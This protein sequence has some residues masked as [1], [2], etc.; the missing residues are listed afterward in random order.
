MN[1]KEWLLKAGVMLGSSKTL[2]GETL[3]ENDI[4]VFG[5]LGND[6]YFGVAN[7]AFQVEGACNVDGK[8][9]SIWDEFSV[10]K[11][12]I[13]NGHNALE[14]CDFY[15]RFSED[16][17]LAKSLGFKHFRFSISWTRV[18][19]TD[20]V[21]KNQSGINFYKNVLYAILK[22]GLQPW[23][24]LY[25]WD[26]PK[27][28]EDEGGWASRRV[29]Q[30]FDSYVKLCANE[31]GGLVERWILV[32]EPAAFVSL[33][34]LNGYHAPGRKS[35]FAFL[36]AVHYVCLAVAQAGRSLREICPNS[37]VGI[38]YNYSPVHGNSTKDHL[39]VKR[40]DAFINRLFVEPFLG[41][42]YPSGDLPVLKRL[43]RYIDSGDMDKIKFSF[44]FVG[45]QYY[46][47]VVV[48]SSPWIPFFGGREIPAAKRG[49]TMNSMKRE[50]YPEGMLESIERFHAYGFKEIVVT[51]NGVCYN[52]VLK[53]INDVEVIEDQKRI[54][55]YRDHLEQ[56]MIAK[57]NGAPVTG[58]FAWS[59]TD[60]FEW[61]E[62]YVDR[63]GL[64]YLDFTTQ[65]RI[66]K[67]SGRWWK[68]HLCS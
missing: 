15:H 23:V 19:Q 32:N 67:D 7:A 24:T 8:L 40:V 49:V 20:L 13:K 25:H 21:S 11:G 48:G 38:A 46:F 41:F 31:F 33:G 2:L 3:A 18:V 55:F 53:V 36:R 43:D 52:D 66:L 30:Y 51:E 56:V 1:R 68:R 22:A 39:V 42:G 27:V 12:N 5:D 14:A 29:V 63:F 62:G 50:I 35:P 64:V 61:A 54:E 65:R 17:A 59:L 44:D 45:V 4:K 6:F 60:N 47:R 28:I 9:P 58:F 10:Q 37:K 34:Y 57:N 26:L 16:I